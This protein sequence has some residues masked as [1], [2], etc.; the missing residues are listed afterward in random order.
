MKRILIFSIILILT[1]SLF[2]ILC[3]C[4]INNQLEEPTESNTADSAIEEESSEETTDNDIPIYITHGNAAQIFDSLEKLLLAVADIDKFCKVVNTNSVGEPVNPDFVSER[5]EVF[6]EYHSFIYMDNYVNS[7]ARLE[8]DTLEVSYTTE[9][10]IV[11]SFYYIYPHGIAELNLYSDK[12]G[13][14]KIDDTVVELFL[15][16]GGKPNQYWGVLRDHDSDAINF[17]IV[18]SCND[19]EGCEKF[20]EFYTVDLVELASEYDFSD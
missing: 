6:S 13:E 5:L 2:F 7:Y 18:I 12:C 19:S 14:V 11:Y 20:A 15:R 8:E 10:G 1:L 9:D 17:I 16:E 4:N 3:S